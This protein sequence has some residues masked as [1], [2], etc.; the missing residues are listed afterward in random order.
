MVVAE[1][2]VGAAFTGGEPL[3]RPGDDV[4]I[5]LAAGGKVFIILPVAEVIVRLPHPDPLFRRKDP[6]EVH[7]DRRVEALHPGDQHIKVVH[8]LPG[9]EAPERLVRV[10]EQPA[11]DAPPVH[12]A[13]HEIL[14]GL[15]GRAGRRDAFRGK[16]IAHVRTGR[17]GV[18]DALVLIDVEVRAQLPEFQAERGHAHGRSERGR[19]TG[20]DAGPLRE[21]GREGAVHHVRDPPLLVPALPGQVADTVLRLG[22]ERHEDGTDLLAVRRQV[23]LRRRFRQRLVHDGIRLGGIGIAG[24]VPA[25]MADVNGLIA[26]GSRGRRRD[27]E[28]IDDIRSASQDRVLPDVVTDIRPLGGARQDKCDEGREDERV[29]QDTSVHVFA[30]FCAKLR[31]TPETASPPAMGLQ[32]EIKII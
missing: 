9:G 1:T 31:K 11:E 26:G 22:I 13:E 24:A 6:G 3:I 23:V 5:D 20:L 7:G 2:E 19:H 18:H 21:S 29:A 8:H 32:S 16:G 28:R 25:V 4:V 10:L 14:R 15:L 30:G 12:R 17:P 27:I